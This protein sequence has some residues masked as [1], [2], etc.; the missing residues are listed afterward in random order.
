MSKILP[1]AALLVDDAGLRI[2]GLK[3]PDG[4][5]SPIPTSWKSAIASSKADDDA[6]ERDLAAII[7]PRGA[8]QVNSALRI[9]AHWTVPNSAATKRLRA[10]FGGTVLYNLDIT[11]SVAFT[12]Q[13]VLMNRNSLS[14]QMGGPNNVASL[15]TFGSNAIQTAFTVDF[16]TAQTLT[17]TGQWPV[18]GA[19]SNNITLEGYIVEV[20]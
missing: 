15:S 9:T 19:G 8:M 1:Q 13:F 10:R 14:S 12:H 11:T 5:D 4:S 7:I 3:N 17:L 6:N 20:L 18:A 2:T 16:A